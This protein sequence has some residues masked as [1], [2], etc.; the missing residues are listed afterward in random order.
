MEPTQKP[1]ETQIAEL[2]RQLQEKR[3]QLGQ[4]GSAPYERAEVH[5]AVGE[6]IKQSVPSY[7]PASPTA[8]TGTQMPSW[9][10]PALAG[11]I[12]QLINVAFTQGVQAAVDQV[13]K[14]DNAA[15]IDALHDA[16]AD[17]FYDELVSRRTITPTD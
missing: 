9:Q 5:Q 16:L 10:D 17:Q 8:A 4:E 14:T 3:A 15:L 6:Q 1:L 7:Q 2:E 12:Q 13:M 11:T